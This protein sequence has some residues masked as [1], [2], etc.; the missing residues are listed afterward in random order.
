MGVQVTMEG[1]EDDV[2]AD[3]CRV[4]GADR[5][6]G[7]LFGRPVSWSKAAELI[8]ELPPDPPSEADQAWREIS[9]EG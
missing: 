2:E 5:G 7:W 1:I 4:I 6:Q 8:A 3:S 9:A